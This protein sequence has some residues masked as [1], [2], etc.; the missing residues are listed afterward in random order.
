MA[1]PLDL[2][3]VRDYLGVPT[4]A[5]SD[6]DL[7][8]MLNASAD[9]QAKRCRWGQD[10]DPVAPYPDALAQAL[11]RR[12]QREVAARNLPLGMVGLDAAE[13][14]PQRLPYLDALVED[15]ERAYRRQV[16]A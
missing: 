15:H 14:G 4:T 8:R 16:L 3:T 1:A 13:Y 5:L 9:N 2:E 6:A 7:T 10:D 12:V 11:L